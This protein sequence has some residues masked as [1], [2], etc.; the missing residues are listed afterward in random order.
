MTDLEGRLDLTL[1]CEDGRVAAVAVHNHRQTQAGRMFIGRRPEE[2]T[3]MLPLL[4]SLCGHAQLVA[5]LEA[6]EQALGV[7]SPPEVAAARRLMVAAE[8]V[9][10]QAQGVLRDWPALLGESPDLAAMRGLRAA[11]GSLRG[12]LFPEREWA[13]PGGGRLVPDLP[14][15]GR[16][17][18]EA[19]RILEQAVFAG[20]VGYCLSDLCAWADWVRTGATA[21]A[22][23]LRHVEDHDLDGLGA[24]A[25]PL[26]PEL[27][28]ADLDAHLAADDGSFVA[29]P[30]WQGRPHLTHPLVRRA[31]HPVVSALLLRHGTGVLPLLAARLADLVECLEELDRWERGHPARTGAGGGG[32]I[33]AGKMPALPGT[34]GLGLVHAA[35]GLLAHRVE[36]AA[37]KIARYQILAPT[38]WIFHPDG[39]IQGLRGLADDETTEARARLLVAALDPCVG[40]TIKILRKKVE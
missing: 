13:R 27:D 26:L 22:R 5:G 19:R 9:L 8:T 23:L 40:C 15:L 29:R 28:R 14:D 16:R 2:V 12:A 25:V 35:R 3:A 17:L 30:L 7:M 34:S 33:V 39:V 1:D 11:L 18:E 24:S 10:E 31:G 36:L 32:E 38:E 20:P 6:V 37:G 21:A 4:F